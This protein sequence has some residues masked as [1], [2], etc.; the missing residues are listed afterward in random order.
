MSIDPTPGAKPLTPPP[1][2]SWGEIAPAG[3]TAAVMR[4]VLVDR[5]VSYPAVEFQRWEHV[6]GVPEILTLTTDKEL[7]MVEGRELT[8]IRAALDLGRLCELRVNYPPKT[9]KRPGPQ[10]QR[11][12]IEAT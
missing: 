6:L 4:F 2:P 10:V 11:I 9:G 3:E 8:E 7:V 1:P 5:V 12:A